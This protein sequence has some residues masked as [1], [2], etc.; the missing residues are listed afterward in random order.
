MEAGMTTAKPK[1]SDGHPDTEPTALREQIEQLTAAIERAAKAEGADAVKAASEAARDIAARVTA[2]VDE[3]A[4]KAGA[5][6]RRKQLEA[7]IREQP[8]I[9]VALAAA[10]GFILASLLRR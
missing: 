6:E 1:D 8:L 2:L 7:S 9:A 5:G 3:F 4:A 10:A